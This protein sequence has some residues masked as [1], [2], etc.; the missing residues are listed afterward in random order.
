MEMAVVL[1][2]VTHVAWEPL[3][4]VNTLPRGNYGGPRIL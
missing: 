3:H 4:V 2:Y 1:G